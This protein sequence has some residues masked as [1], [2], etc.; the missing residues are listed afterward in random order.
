MVGELAGRLVG[1]A[2]RWAQGCI[3]ERRVEVEL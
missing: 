3:A 2:E 1:I